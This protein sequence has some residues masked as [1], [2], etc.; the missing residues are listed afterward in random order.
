MN[1]QWYHHRNDYEMEYTA[2]VKVP[3]KEVLLDFLKMAL[4]G[5]LDGFVIKIGITHVVGGDQYN[6]KIGRQK[7]V[8]NF[9]DFTFKDFEIILGFEGIV[10]IIF[11]NMLTSVTFEIK[12]NRKRVY[13]IGVDA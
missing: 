9:R 1:V 7:S 4:N 3:E 12:E 5:Q 11:K 10:H 13:L 2:A 6:K 8:Q